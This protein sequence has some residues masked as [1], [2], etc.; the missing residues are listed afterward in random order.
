MA[1]RT[2]CVLATTSSPPPLQRKKCSNARSPAAD[3][4]IG[5]S[6]GGDAHGTGSASVFAISRWVRIRSRR[7]RVFASDLAVAPVGGQLSTPLIPQHAA[8]GSL[9][10]TLCVMN[11]AGTSGVVAL[12]HPLIVVASVNAPSSFVSHNS[13]LF[14]TIR[15]D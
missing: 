14:R 10:V 6:S 2:V 4:I 15:T 9:G 7:D 3:L 13:F 8:S 5:G 12:V 11:T 1:Y